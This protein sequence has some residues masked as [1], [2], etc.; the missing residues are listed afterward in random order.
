MA[1]TYMTNKYNALC[2]KYKSIRKESVR[3]MYYNHKVGKKLYE[4]YS[5]SMYV[6]SLM[7]KDYYELDDSFCEH[8][9]SYVLRR[10]TCEGKVA[11]GIAESFEFYDQ[12]N[13]DS[14]SRGEVEFD[15]YD[16]ALDYFNS[17]RGTVCN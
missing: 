17:L 11:Y 13:Y 5:P 7:E 1:N 12:A 9:T 16:E 2:G 10:L 6:E 3:P 14:G 4:V 15:D 8:T